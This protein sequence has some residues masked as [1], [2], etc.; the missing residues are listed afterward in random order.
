MNKTTVALS[1]EEY[2]KVVSTIQYGFEYKNTKCYP[3]PQIATA[4]IIQANTGLRIGDLLNLKLSSI[5]RENGRYHFNITEQ[6]TKKKRTFTIA[7]EVYTYMQEYALAN[8]IKPDSKLFNISSRGVSKHLKKACDY[9]GMEG[10]GTHSFRKF[11]AMSI[12]N[13][14]GY[15]IEIVKTLLAHSSVAVTELYLSVS[16]QV[17]EKALLNHV[18]IPELNVVS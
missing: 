17:V 13:D 8:G 7:P 16:P 1:K 15:N 6:K 18:Y 3:N 14:N 2:E 9:L 11:F 5:V 10:V 4:L 12:Y